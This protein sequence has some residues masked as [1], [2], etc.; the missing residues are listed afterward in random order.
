MGFYFALKPANLIKRV[1]RLM[2]V[3]MAQKYGE[4]SSAVTVRPSV[5]LSDLFATFFFLSPVNVFF[6]SFDFCLH[7]HI[8]LFLFFLIYSS[9]C[10][11]RIYL[12]LF[13]FHSFKSEPW[14]CISILRTIHVKVILFSYLI[15]KKMNERITDS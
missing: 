3:Y 7:L 4:N 11:I 10:I 9:V 2:W 12:F 14:V 5:C 6:F 8:S 13:F 15:L 1:I